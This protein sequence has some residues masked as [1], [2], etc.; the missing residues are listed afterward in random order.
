M[1][2]ENCQ[3]LVQTCFK[4]TKVT[5][6]VANKQTSSKFMHNLLKESKQSDFSPKTHN[7]KTKTSR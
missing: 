2:K 6:N 5:T 3:G 7:Y 1:G 4:M